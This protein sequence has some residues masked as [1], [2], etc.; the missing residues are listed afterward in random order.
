M[1]RLLLAVATG[2][3]V[4][5]AAAQ[6]GY[7]E[8]PIRVLIGF[9]AGSTADVAGRLIGQKWSEA[10]GKPVVVENLAGAAGN[11]A[12]ERVVKATPDG[13]T[14]ALAV[15]AQLTVNPSLYKLSYDP[16]KD[17]APIS[18][19]YVAANFLVVPP[20]VPA[21]T[22]E[23][24]LALAR[25][26]PCTLTFASGG[27]GSSPH[28]A[29]ELLKS[30][31]RL[32]IRH[33]PYKGVVAGVPDL[34]AGRVTMMFAPSS[35]AVAPV[36]TGKLRAL[37]VTSLKRSPALPEVPTVAES[38]FPGFEATIWGGLVA[39]A[40]TPTAVIQKLHGE[41]AGALAHA[42]VRG[43]L[44]EAGLEPIG[45]SPAE[46]AMVIKSEIPKWAKL[47]ADSGM[48]AD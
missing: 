30:A 43:R 20:S 5:H 8:K 16:A 36:R 6:G 38:G 47:I 33:V 32:D 22:F 18:Q 7:P 21:K 41:S 14:L 48:R 27:G 40:G 12:L 35:V 3:A 44:A 19:L 46:F 23:E 39:P 9:P 45:N 1:T 11:I 37:A 42:D 24:L 31:A 13:Y 28:I 25:A 29:A 17:L 4:S 26:Q 34:L 15:N 10:M 2:V